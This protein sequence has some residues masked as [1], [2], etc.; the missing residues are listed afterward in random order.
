[1]N[2]AYNYE[3][4]SMMFPLVTIIGLQ[5]NRTILP[6]LLVYLISLLVEPKANDGHASPSV[7][8]NLRKY[9][10]QIAG[11]GVSGL[12]ISKMFRGSMPPNPLVMRGLG[13]TVSF[14]SG[15]AP[16]FNTDQCRKRTLDRSSTCFQRS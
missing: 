6:K 14:G 1:M 13:A 5:F 12:Q 9:A 4:T 3:F 11:N 10:S 15:S 7:D 16:A 2:N 8:R